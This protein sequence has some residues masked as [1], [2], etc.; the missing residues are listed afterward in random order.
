MN[1]FHN[2]QFWFVK[3]GFLKFVNNNKSVFTNALMEKLSDVQPIINIVEL[4]GQE[5]NDTHTFLET[6]LTALVSMNQIIE[7]K[8]WNI[9]A[10][11]LIWGALIDEAIH[12]IENNIMSLISS[13]AMQYNIIPSNNIALLEIITNLNK[14][15][16]N[17]CY[18][19][20]GTYGAS[21]L[22]TMPMFQPTLSSGLPSKIYQLGKIFV[23]ELESIPILVDPYMT[24][25]NR[26]MYVVRKDNNELHFYKE[27]DLLHNVDLIDEPNEYKKM[28]I[29]IRYAVKYEGK[30]DDQDF[31]KVTLPDNAIDPEYYI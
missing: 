23:N 1:M 20:T 24:Y 14:Q 28:N 16:R 3:K 2:W 7:L 25:G 8:K 19:V 4:D 10:I 31:I 13:N 30:V 26:V 12:R 5:S 27:N 15:Y 18:I 11:K 22:Q 6:T 29:E 17:N 21:V 9:N